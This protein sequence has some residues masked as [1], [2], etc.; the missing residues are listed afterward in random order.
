[1]GTLLAQ[2]ERGWA[3]ES[4]RQASLLAE[5]STWFERVKQF[6]ETEMEIMILR[7]AAPTEKRFHRAHL[8]QVIAQGESLVVRAMLHG[9]PK[10]EQGI[11]LDSMEAELHSLLLNQS[12]WY[13]EVTD[14]R[15]QQLFREVFGDEKSQA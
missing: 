6:R 12:Q 9:L 10:N 15:K 3:D 11:T 7:N 1:M 5:S 8:A 14:P 13:S 2:M 4:T